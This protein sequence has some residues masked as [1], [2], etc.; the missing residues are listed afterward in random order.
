MWKGIKKEEDISDLGGKG[1]EGG[2]DDKGR[3][4]GCRNMLKIDWMNS[5]RVNKNIILK[6][7]N[8]GC[9]YAHCSLLLYI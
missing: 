5:Q 9:I 7:S 6:C 8:H 3:S 2:E 4:S 1:S